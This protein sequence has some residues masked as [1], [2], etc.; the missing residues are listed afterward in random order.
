MLWIKKMGGKRLDSK[1]IN[2]IRNWNAIP[3]KRERSHVTRQCE[4]CGEIFVVPLQKMGRTRRGEIHYVISKRR[5]CSAVCAKGL[6]AS[7]L[8][9]RHEA[10]RAADPQAYTDWL[11]A[12][13]SHIGSTKNGQTPTRISRSPI[14]AETRDGTSG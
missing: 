6:H 11:A 14:R 7:A 13:R 5:S 4:N 2:R 1:T 9:K 10:A 3:R 12:V 8:S